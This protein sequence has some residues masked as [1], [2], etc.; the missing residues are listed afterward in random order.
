MSVD[1]TCLGSIGEILLIFSEMIRIG[2]MDGKGR[3]VDSG[4]IERLRRSVKYEEIYLR[5]YANG[6]EARAS[7][8]IFFRFYNERRLLENLNYATPDEVYFGELA[9]STRAAA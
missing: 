5:A 4:F 1:S 8:Q 6:T 7:L 3:W 2:G 9:A